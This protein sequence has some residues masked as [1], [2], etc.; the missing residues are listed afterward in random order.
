MSQPALKE[1]QETSDLPTREEKIG[2]Y[3]SQGHTPMMAQYHTLKSE[4]QDCLLFYRMGDFY[5]LFYDDA[6][7]ASRV[8]DITLTKRGKSNGDDIAMCGVPFHSCEPYL[9]KLVKSGHKVAI[10]EQTETPDEAKA[11]AKKEGKSASKALVNREAVRVV[12]QGTLTE[13]NLLDAKN[14]NYICSIFAQKKTFGVAWLDLSTGDFK[15]QENTEDTVRATLE[16]IAPSEII[17]P[18]TLIEQSPDLFMHYKHKTSPLPASL[19]SSAN[20]LSNLKKIYNIETIDSFGQF[21]ENEITAAG[22]LI[23]YIFRTQKGHLP[24]LSSPQKIST[25]SIMEIDAS[26]RKSLELT[27]TLSGERKGSLLD[28]IDYTVTSAGARLLQSCLSAPLSVAEQINHRLNRVE[29]MHKNDDLRT[30]TREFLRSMPDMER[31]LSRLTI[32]RGGPKD[33]CAIR[34]GLQQSEVIRAELQHDNDSREKL[35]KIL[36]SLQ[37]TPEVNAL[38]DTL[39]L[40]LEDCAPLLA[41]DG[42]F[43]RTGYSAPLDELRLLRDNSRKLIAALQEKYKKHA[44]VDALKIKHNN[45]LG[46]FV[47]VPAKRADTLMQ[48]NEDNVFIHRQTM[49]NAIR[50]TT[51]ELAE[52]EKDITSSA[53]KIIAIELDIF[54]K[55]L[56]KTEAVSNEICTIAR[57]ISKVDTTCALAELSR[58]MG[59]TKPIVDSSLQF[60]IQGGRHPVVEKVLKK[61]S[62]AFVSNNC[63]LEPQQKL[64][65]LTG[66]N[67]AGKSTFLRQNALI[68]IL[69]QIGSY[70]PADSAHIGVVDKVF[71]RVGASDDLARGQSTFMVEMVETASILHQSTQHS[72]VILDEIGRGTATYDGLSI[73]WACV[74]YL[75]EQNQCRA[76]FATHY[77]EL[78]SLEQKL[79]KLICYTMQIK[80]WENKIIFMHKVKRG[81]ADRSYGIHVA[82]LAGIPDPV[83]HRAEEILNTLQSKNKT[84][85]ASKAIDDLPLFTSSEPQPEPKQK[86]AVEEKLSKIVPDELTPR[87]ALDILYTLKS[88]TE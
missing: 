78:T 20:A 35:H 6:I 83:I 3:L 48:K 39:S 31:A 49:A 62:A 10:C 7:T 57:S 14:N 82:Q 26:T 22:I 63:N 44:A 87:E 73:A 55:I 80:E 42:N 69:A 25:G 40:A 34:D 46:F 11:R 75:H 38:Q 53:D 1:I 30:I 16:R 88:I 15:T 77:H 60:N 81:S 45:V 19:F 24:H 17:L 12:T 36:T 65:L 43:I 29:C 28:T 50:F 76:I 79:S 27:R 71:S 64:W 2:V 9:A 8:L 13:D 56:R 66:P 23:D 4:H 54:E 51:V 85:S 58:D 47:E 18:D 86:S 74:E 41:R 5:E 67:M 21:S 33:L 84:P 52:L 72:L 68:A 70:V 59:Y 61:E 37:Q 32:G